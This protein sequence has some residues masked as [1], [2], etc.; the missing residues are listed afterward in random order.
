MILIIRL[1]I[2]FLVL[3]NF[4]FSSNKLFILPVLQIFMELKFL[5]YFFIKV[6]RGFIVFL[7]L[8]YNRYIYYSVGLTINYGYVFIYAIRFVFIL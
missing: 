1:Y 4:S 8:N 3:N 6:I 5:R 7:F 2:L